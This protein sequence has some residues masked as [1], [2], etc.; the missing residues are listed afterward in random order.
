MS[1]R[2]ITFMCNGIICKSFR[3]ND[4]ERICSYMYDI[5]HYCIEWKSF[6]ICDWDRGR[7]FFFE[8]V[9]PILVEK[10][11]IHDD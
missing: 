4:M 5:R 2:I 3:C 1:D 6:M 11:L 10:G 9:Y 7:E 8:D